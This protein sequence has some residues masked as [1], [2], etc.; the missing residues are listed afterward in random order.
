MIRMEILPSIDIISGK[1]A[2]LIQGKFEKIKFYE[3]FGSPIEVAK[4]WESLGANGLHIIDIDAALNIG[5]NREIIY[6]IIKSINIPIQVGGGIRSIK[7]AK[8]ILNIGAER[9][10]IGSIAFTSNEIIEEILNEYGEERLIIA[11]DHANGIV[12]ING[13]RLSTGIRVEEAI[14]K[15]KDKG[16]KLFLVTSILKDGLLSGTDIDILK[17]IC[18]IEGIKIF[19]AGGITTMDDINLLENVGVSAVIIGRALY[20]GMLNLKEIVDNIK[21]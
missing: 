20:E 6:E 5:N 15:F 9:I 4:K 12:M 16:A 19:A 11:I 21:R 10:I 3:N 2:R 7:D 1:V 13:W 8:H 17:K 14:K 18:R